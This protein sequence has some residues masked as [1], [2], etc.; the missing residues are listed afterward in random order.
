MDFNLIELIN[1]FQKY[2]VGFLDK[3]ETFKLY[4]GILP[5]KKYFLRYIKS[6]NTQNYNPELLDYLSI[7]FQSSKADVMEYLDIYYKNEHGVREVEDILRK[8]GLND[9]KIKTLTKLK[10]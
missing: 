6:K 3:R 8:Y 1:I 2:T 4:S 7:Y 9:K 10:K 5:Q